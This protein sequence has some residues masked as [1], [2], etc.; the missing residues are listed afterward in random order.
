MMA[1]HKDYRDQ[2]FLPLLWFWVRCFI[3]EN[4]TLE[5]FNTDSPPGHVMIKATQLLN[6][7]IDR[8][9]GQPI[10]DKEFFYDYA[11]FS[12]R[13]QKGFGALMSTRRPP[14]EEA[15]LYIPL[16]SKEQIRDR[17]T[18]DVGPEAI[19]YKINRGACSCDTCRRL[20]VGMVRCGRCKL[21]YYCDKACQ[22][23]DWKRH[24]QWCGLTR[25]QL[26]ELLVEK[27]L[28]QRMEDGNYA[29]IHGV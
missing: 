29:S 7:E 16:L 25:D 21:V 2:K 20:S 12:V 10:S 9:K 5:C 13:A 3:E 1:V 19:T 4:I 24:K 11:G 14:D 28:R 15:V 22:K 6:A 23:K 17:T 26:H 27:G 18:Y 8:H